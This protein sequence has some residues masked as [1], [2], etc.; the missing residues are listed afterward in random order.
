MRLDGHH[1]EADLP[2]DYNP[3]NLS[4]TK[5]DGCFRIS[6]NGVNYLADYSIELAAAGSAV[7]WGTVDWTKVYEEGAN[8]FM[9]LTCDTVT[10]AAADEVDVCALFE[11]E[12]DRA[13]EAGWGGAEVYLDAVTDPAFVTDIATA[14][15]NVPSGAALTLETESKSEAR[16]F[17]TV[18]YDADG[19]GKPNN[20]LY[21]DTDDLGAGL[22]GR[23]KS[24]QTVSKTAARTRGTG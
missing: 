6:A 21:A 10:V 4:V 18:W 19:D 13:L 5:P 11:D 8:P 17:S 2:S 7:S 12:V 14:D 23:A 24:M 16:Q 22:T 1:G 15:A 3:A 20:D 9:D